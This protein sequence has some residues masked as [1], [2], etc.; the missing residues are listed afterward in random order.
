[1]RKIAASP[2]TEMR[3][4]GMEEKK[5]LR[6]GDLLLQSSIISEAQLMAALAEQKKTGRKLGRSLIELGYVDEDQLLHV[7]SQHFKIP[8]IQLRQYQ[9][10]TNLVKRLPETLSRRFRAIV[11]AEQSGGLLVGMSDPMDIIA[12]DELVRSLKQPVHLAVVRESD[13]LDAL[14]RAYRRHDEIATIAGELEDELRDE[15]FDLAELAAGGDVN[16]APVVRLLQSIF[17]DA[18]VARASDIHIEPDETV[19]RIRQRIDGVLH[20]TGDERTQDHGGACVAPEADVWPEY[21]R[22]AFAAGWQV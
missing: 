7:L 13:L 8:F 15:V 4:G 12:Y 9:L 10:N 19:V 16:D 11:L 14:D 20:E 22:K 5:K 3:A 1:M 21:L 17:E 6:L 2:H 18:V